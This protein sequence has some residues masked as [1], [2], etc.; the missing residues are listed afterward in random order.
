MAWE[1]GVRNLLVET[2]I[3]CIVSLILGQEMAMGSHA[4]FVRGI[5]GLLSLAWQVQVYHINREC[6]L[7][8]DKMAAMAN[9]LPLGYH[10]FQEPPQG[11]LQWLSHDK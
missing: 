4:S 8:A 5:R 6:N 11:Y 3:T 10:F 2:N 1:C 9:D 7:V